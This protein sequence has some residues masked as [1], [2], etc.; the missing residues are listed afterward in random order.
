VTVNMQALW[1][2]FDPQMLELNIPVLGEVRSAWQY[3]FGDAL[4][5]GAHIAAGSDWPVTSP[6]PWLALHV[7]VN[8]TLSPDSPDFNATPF[9]PEQALNLADALAAY[10]RHSAWLNHDDAAGRIAVGAVA[11]IVVADRDPFADH[12]QYIASTQTRATYVGGVEVFQATHKSHH[13]E[14]RE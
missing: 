4:R 13:Q 1:A 5:A 3:P 10:T 7:A 2:T 8:R 9:Y 6:N 11:D 14:K 12:P